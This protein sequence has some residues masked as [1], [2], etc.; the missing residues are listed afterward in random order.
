MLSSVGFHLF[1]YSRTVNRFASCV[2]VERG[3]R[4]IDSLLAGT[5]NQGDL[6]IPRSALN[7]VC[8]TLNCALT[9]F[10]LPSLTLERMF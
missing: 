1:I 3:A 5:Q 6:S 9:D 2:G 10:T 8:N 4:L 7:P